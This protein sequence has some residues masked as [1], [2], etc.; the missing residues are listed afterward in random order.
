MTMIFHSGHSIIIDE[1]TITPLDGAYLIRGTSDGRY[2]HSYTA[3]KPSK[4][5]AIKIIADLHA[6]YIHR[7]IAERFYP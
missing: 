7:K 2:Y 6:E 1:L 4:K 5:D 3:R